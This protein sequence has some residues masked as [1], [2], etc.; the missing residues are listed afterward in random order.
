MFEWPRKSSLTSTGIRRLWWLCLIF[1]A[2]FHNF[3]TIY[4]FGVK[5]PS[6]TFLLSYNVC[7]WVTSKIQLNF[8]FTNFFVFV[9]VICYSRLVFVHLTFNRPSGVPGDPRATKIAISLKPAEIRCWNFLTF[10][11]HML[12]SDWWY[13]RH[14]TLLP[15]RHTWH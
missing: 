15:W 5:D 7:L 8:R 4:V 14:V 1:M 12:T 10:I 6:L 9:M 2:Y 3:F 13:C 11:I